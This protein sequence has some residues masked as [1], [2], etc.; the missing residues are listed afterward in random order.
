MPAH[1]DPLA[2]SPSG[3]A[4]AQGIDD[5]CYFVARDSRVLNAGKASLYRENITVADAASLDL[6]P[7]VP[8]DGVWDVA[9]Y[10]FK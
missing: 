4:P 5:P 10:Q 9:F 8:R 1:S 7:D 2:G 6:D 3:D